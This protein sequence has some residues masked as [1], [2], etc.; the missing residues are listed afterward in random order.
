MPQNNSGVPR[1]M[2]GVWQSIQYGL[3]YVG[4]QS[5]G[6]PWGGGGTPE[7][8]GLLWVLSVNIPTYSVSIGSRLL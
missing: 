7:M 1:F 4:T 3:E 2:A 6:V 8:W 5:R